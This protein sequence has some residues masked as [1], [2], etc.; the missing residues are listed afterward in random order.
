MVESNPE[1]GRVTRWHWEKLAKAAKQ[2]RDRGC[3]QYLRIMKL[4]WLTFK[5]KEITQPMIGKL[6]DRALEV[7]QYYLENRV[8]A[9]Y[10]G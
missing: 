9:R 7:C 3:T 2:S 5:M 1:P 10:E 4:T 8:V 6:V